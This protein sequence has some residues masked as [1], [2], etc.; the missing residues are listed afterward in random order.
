MTRREAVR[1]AA[2]A[3][4]LLAA[5]VAALALGVGAHEAV[6]LV[7]LAGAIVGG[8][9][10]LSLRIGDP[11][12][13]P[14]SY[15]LFPVV[16]AQYSARAYAVTAGGAEIIA[17]LLMWATLR[18]RRGGVSATLAT[19]AAVVIG[20]FVSYHASFGF[21][22]ERE[23]LEPILV[24]LTLAA[25][26]ALVLDE[27]ARRARGVASAFAGRGPVA[28]LALGSSGVLMAIGSRGVADRGH[29]G[30]WGVA[31]FSSSLLAAWYSF[32]RLDAITRVSRQT[33]DALTLA[34][35]LAGL[36][37]AGHAERVAA[38]SVRVA[39][40][41]QFAPDDVRALGAAA[42]LHHLGAVI[43]DDDNHHEL[44]RVG[45][46]GMTATMLRDIATLAPVRSVLDGRNRA[47]ADVLRI[48]DGYDNFTGGD[49]RRSR[50]ALVALASASEDPYDAVVFEALRAVVEGRR[51]GNVVHV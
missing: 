5:L 19:R 3:L 30:L 12:P 50:D 8:E 29:L 41:L 13:L 10:V 24:S 20:V 46:H 49:E 38:L 28:W 31:L 32:E 9:V 51:E 17:V 35:E 11:E 25:I 2:P 39:Q 14:V 37:P 6:A 4:A 7:L 47:A 36:V 27:L 21:L 43:V 33:I 15:A 44:G 42:R 34:P 45:V 40:R 16:A 26:S 18:R 22:H 23:A 48:A 1:F